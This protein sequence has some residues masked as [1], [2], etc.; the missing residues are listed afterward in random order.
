MTSHS[1][2]ILMF[3]GME[4]SQ[5]CFFVPVNEVS[6]EVNWV[7]MQLV[8]INRQKAGS[9][10]LIVWPCPGNTAIRYFCYCVYTIFMLLH[11]LFLCYCS[12]CFKLRSRCTTVSH[13]VSKLVRTVK[14]SGKLHSFDLLPS[15]RTSTYMYVVQD[16]MFDTCF[17]KADRCH[18]EMEG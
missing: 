9:L 3:V 13:L 2:H 5:L 16:T 1:V 14:C 17:L 4:H 12:C 6:E 11:V 8:P 15:L 18:Q 7:C 10:K